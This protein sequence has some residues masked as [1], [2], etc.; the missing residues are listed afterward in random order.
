MGMTAEAEIRL[1]VLLGGGGRTR[2]YEAIRRLIYSQLPL[3]LGTLPLGGA[4]LSQRNILRNGRIVIAPVILERH[5]APRSERLFPWR[6]WRQS[7]GHMRR[8][9]EPRTAHAVSRPS[10]CAGAA[11]AL[12]SA[13]PNAR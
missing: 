6:S 1:A 3:P 5:S 10:A 12:C 4:Y 13:S 11:G 2:T 9:S 7:R 8:S